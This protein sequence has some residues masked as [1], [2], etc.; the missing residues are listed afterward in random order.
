MHTRR[1]RIVSHLQVRSPATLPTLTLPKP[2]AEAR[3]PE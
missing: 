3:L 2:T 1:M